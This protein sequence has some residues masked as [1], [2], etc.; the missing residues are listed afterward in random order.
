MLKK[1]IILI[2]GVVV[3]LVSILIIWKPLNTESE[4][5]E[6]GLIF[7]SEHECFAHCNELRDN[8][9]LIMNKTPAMAFPHVYGP[10]SGAC[11]CGSLVFQ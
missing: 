10:D 9:T 5:H 8:E 11:V 3:L 7:G 6:P 2:V 1:H 4:I